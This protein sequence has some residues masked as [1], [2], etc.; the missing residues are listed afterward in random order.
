MNVDMSLHTVLWIVA[1][2]AG[3]GVLVF[4]VRSFR[5]CSKHTAMRGH[6]QHILEDHDPLHHSR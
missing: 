3:C 2:L 6:L 5:V 1:A 4:V